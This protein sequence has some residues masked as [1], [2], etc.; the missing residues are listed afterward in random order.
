MNPIAKAEVAVDSLSTCLIDG[1]SNLIKIG[2]VPGHWRHGKARYFRIVG[3][4]LKEVEK[5]AFGFIRVDYR[6]VR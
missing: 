3:Q 6:G 1:L 5:Q 4:M 2:G